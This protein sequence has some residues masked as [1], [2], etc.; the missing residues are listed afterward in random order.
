MLAWLHPRAGTA[1]TRRLRLGARATRLRGASTWRGWPR[2]ASPLSDPTSQHAGRDVAD[3]ASCGLQH[4]VIRE[5]STYPRDGDAQTFD[6]FLRT[7]GSDDNLP[8]TVDL[9]RP[10][11]GKRPATSGGG[12]GSSAWLV[13]EL[14]PEFD[15]NTMNIIDEPGSA[16]PDRWRAGQPERPQ[17]RVGRPGSVASSYL[18][19]GAARL[20]VVPSPSVFPDLSARDKEATS[21]RTHIAG[22][23][24]TPRQLKA[25][26]DQHVI[27]QEEAKRALAVAVCDHYNF[28]RRCLASPAASERHYVKPNVLLLGPSGSGKTHLLRALTRLLR[29][30]FVK[31]DATKF[32]A[33]GY[34]GG[35]VEDMV[36]ALVP[37]ADGDVELAEFGIVYVDE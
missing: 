19:A 23:N 13:D 21:R 36:R 1:G 37:A 33:T 7:V 34:V 32:S 22:F 2:P 24:L 8:K 18:Q 14:A 29:V 35:D 10:P 31:A 30:P 6:V 3:R 26:L 27:S 16:A 15:V 9:G 5:P 12:G 25:H 17:H 20:P 28:V 11:S 4:V